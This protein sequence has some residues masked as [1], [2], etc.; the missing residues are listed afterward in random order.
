MTSSTNS[1]LATADSVMANGRIV[2][3][4]KISTKENLNQVTSFDMNF[5]VVSHHI[6]RL[7]YSFMAAEAYWITSGSPLVEDIVPYLNHMNEYSDDGVIFN[8]AYGPTFLNQVNYV[9]NTLASDLFSRQAVMTIWHP[10]PIKSK[11]HKCTIAF[12]FYVRGSK[13]NV[14]VQMR[15]SDVFLGLP[16]DM[17]NF[18][19]MTLRVLTLLN[20]QRK[21]EFPIQLGEMRINAVSSHIY[22]SNWDQMQAIVDDDLLQKEYKVPVEVYTEW[23]FI[24]QSLI[25]CRDVKDTTCWGIRP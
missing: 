8:G 17:F 22:A 10:N 18:T 21:D 5:P 14:T 23:N 6:R 2:M 25:G 3:P 16:Y 24:V 4:R 1:W 15:S 20:S 19:I 9:V 11:D 7:N 13:L 12:I